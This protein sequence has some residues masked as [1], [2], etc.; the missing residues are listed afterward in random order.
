[1]EDASTETITRPPDDLVA[2]EIDAIVN[3]KKSSST[4]IAVA[5]T[6]SASSGIAS[7]VHL[8][9]PKS[10]R[11]TPAAKQRQ[12]LTATMLEA[13]QN[14]TKKLA[15]EEDELDLSFAGYA[16]RMRIFLS[17]E[18]KE[19]LNTE[20]G[21]PVSNAI[22]NA[23]AGMPVLQKS[24][25]YRYP[26]MGQGTSNLQNIQNQQPVI[27]TR[28]LSDLPQPPE[29]QPVPHV[30][31]GPEEHQQQNGPTGSFYIQG[32]TSMNYEVGRSF[33]FTSM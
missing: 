22:K 10:K 14:E 20:I 7:K 17:S 4:Q 33:E 29:L 5:S 18:Q 15:D 24:P 2:R 13:F 30:Q 25:V 32:P 12:E 16:K 6:S 9:A 11:Y 26:Q 19:E 8:Q 3:P 28:Q 1:M 23:K 27:G 21:N 31:Q